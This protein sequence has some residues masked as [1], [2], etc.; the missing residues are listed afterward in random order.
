MLETRRLP[1]DPC[2]SG[3]FGASRAQDRIRAEACL[4]ALVI[5]LPERCD[6]GSRAAQKTE[7]RMMYS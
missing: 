7:E 1:L 6:C 5:S 4:A 3:L 2:L